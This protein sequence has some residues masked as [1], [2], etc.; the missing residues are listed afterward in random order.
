M[1]EEQ[2]S[3]TQQQSEEEEVWTWMEKILTATYSF[4]IWA[5]HT[6]PKRPLA[7]TSSSCSG[8][9]P[10]RGEAGGSAGSWGSRET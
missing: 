10:S 7:F 6:E 5:F 1:D 4:I 3:Q 9:S 8:F 2:F